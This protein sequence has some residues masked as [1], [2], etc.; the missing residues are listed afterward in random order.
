LSA[1]P[2]NSSPAFLYVRLARLQHNC[3]VQRIMVDCFTNLYRATPRL[4][5]VVNFILNPT[6]GHMFV[7]RNAE[8]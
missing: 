2:D 7:K 6:S 1:L 3:A 4:L 5:F 8:K